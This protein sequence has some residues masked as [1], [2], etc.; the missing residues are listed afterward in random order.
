MYIKSYRP[1][2][3]SKP[4]NHVFRYV[5]GPFETF[6]YQILRDIVQY[7]INKPVFPLSNF[8]YIGLDVVKLEFIARTGKTQK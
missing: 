7:F 4:Q 6:V 3:C 2:A 5:V 1:F 8:R